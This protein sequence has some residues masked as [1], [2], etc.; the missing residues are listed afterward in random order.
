MSMTPEPSAAWPFYFDRDGHL[1]IPQR[2][3]RSP[4]DADAMNGVVIGGLFMRAADSYPA[5]RACY[6]PICPSTS[7]VLCRAGPAGSPL[8]CFTAA[9]SS[10]W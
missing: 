9:R 3:T 6:R 4:W 7:C 1:L 8:P 5:A 10:S 2:V